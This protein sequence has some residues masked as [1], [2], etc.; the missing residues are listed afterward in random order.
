MSLLARPVWP[1]RRTPPLLR[2]GVFRA[3]DQI[4]GRQVLD[5]F[6]ICFVHAG[7][8]RGLDLPSGAIRYW[9]SKSAQRQL[10]IDILGKVFPSVLFLNL[11]IPR[12]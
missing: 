9:V 7:P 4:S 8:A 1:N 10:E 2:F 3:F 11:M 6:M 5:E 12:G